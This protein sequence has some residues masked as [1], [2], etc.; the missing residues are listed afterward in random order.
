LFDDVDELDWRGTRENFAE[1]AQR[2][3]ALGLVERAERLR[4]IVQQRN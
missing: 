1:V 4:Q 2:I 3:D